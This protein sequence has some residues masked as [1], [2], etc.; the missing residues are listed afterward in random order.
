MQ[1]HSGVDTM[2]SNRSSNYRHD[3]GQFAP[4]QEHL[5]AAAGALRFPERFLRGDDIGQLA[6]ERVSF[7]YG[8]KLTARQRDMALGSAAVAIAFNQEIERLFALPEPDFP[9]LGHRRDPEQ[10]ADF[11]RLKWHVDDG[12]IKSIMPLFES[13]GVRIFSLPADAAAAD[14]FSLW[15][16]D[17]PFILLNLSKREDERRLDLAHE[18]G[19]LLLHRRSPCSGP[20]AQEAAS[21]FALAFLMPTDALRTERLQAHSIDDIVAIGQ[22][23]GV[24]PATAAQRLHQLQLLRWPRLFGQFF[25]FDEWSLCRG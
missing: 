4:N 2:G 24:P 7:R 19:H 1:N 11:L 13:N 9:N 16:R 25:R 10:V 18:L 23:C 6:P 12:P 17:R 3:I 22:K 5:R 8:S 15:H 14:T 21:S 20:K